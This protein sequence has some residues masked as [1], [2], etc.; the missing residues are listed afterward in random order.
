M[1]WDS[2]MRREGKSDK[3]MAH[4]A[5]SRFASGDTKDGTKYSL[6]GLYVRQYVTRVSKKALAR[7]ND[8]DVIVHGKGVDY[9]KL[10][11]FV[12]KGITREH[13]IPVSVL[14]DHL[15]KLYKQSK[16]TEAY[17]LK[18]IPKLQIAVITKEEE[19]KLKDAHLNSSM[20][21]RDAWWN[22]KTLDPLERYRAAGLDDSIW[23][24]GF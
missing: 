19:K 5:Y 4:I 24:N 3:Q 21:G 9:W 7:I 12:K 22:S 8:P 1:A 15:A 20:P 18:L 16:L 23:A 6:G 13:V 17:I 14:Y 2:T 11:G 10:G